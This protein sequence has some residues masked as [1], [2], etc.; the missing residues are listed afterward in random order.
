MKQQQ[1][2][3]I[4]QAE[5]ELKLLIVAVVV[6]ALMV[7]AL[8]DHQNIKNSFFNLL[9]KHR[10][11]YEILRADKRNHLYGCWEHHYG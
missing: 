9:S 7:K 8:L 5:L 1:K 4:A 6:V 2:S 3:E 10:Q 11:V